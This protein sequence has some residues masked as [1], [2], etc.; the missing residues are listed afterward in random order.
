M[1]QLDGLGSYLNLLLDAYWRVSQGL[2]VNWTAVVHPN[3]SSTGFCDG[4]YIDLVSA[5]PFLPS[6]GDSR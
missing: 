2:G 6:K 4:S 3:H 5:C 1:W